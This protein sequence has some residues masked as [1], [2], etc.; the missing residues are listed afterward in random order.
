MKDS[1]INVIAGAIVACVFVTL[2]FGV[3]FLAV[4]GS[5]WVIN[6]VVHS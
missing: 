4:S 5:M 3:M 2:A 1:T 6:A